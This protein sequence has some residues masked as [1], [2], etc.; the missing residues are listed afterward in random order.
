MPWGR[1]RELERVSLRARAAW[2]RVG[3]AAPRIAP[4]IGTG[5]GEKGQKHTIMEYRGLPQRGQVSPPRV[6]GAALQPT[7]QMALTLLR[8]AQRQY[9]EGLQAAYPQAS[10]IIS[11]GLARELEVDEIAV[12]LSRWTRQSVEPFTDWFRNRE[13][14]AYARVF[15]GRG[16][17]GGPPPPAGQR[18]VDY[19]A[20]G[21]PVR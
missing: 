17:P 11:D 21:N 16:L 8:G 6:R 2:A 14:E 1:S 5:R 10:K 3:E 18:V 20:Q 12:E 15:G 13:P 9:L 19:D 4:F 7:D